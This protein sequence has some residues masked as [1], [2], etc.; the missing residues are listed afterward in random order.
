[1]VVGEAG[2]GKT[3]LAREVRR[4]LDAGGWHTELVLCSARVGFSLPALAHAA[5]TEGANEL[6]RVGRSRCL[7]D[8]SKPTVLLVDDAHLLDDESSELLWRVAGGGE[9]LV[10]ATVRSGTRVPDR[11]ARLWADGECTHLPLAPLAEGDV[12]ALLEIVLGGD[13]EDRVPRLLVRRAAGNALLLRELVRSGV[14]S[15]ALE[16]SHEV[17]RLAGELPIAAGATDLIRGNL[18]GLDSDELRALQLLAIC[19]PLRLE[20]A[21][22]IIGHGLMEA[23]E[24]Q[25]ILTMDET[26]DGPVLTFGH[27]L[28]GEVLRADIAP[29]RMRRLQNGADRGHQVHRSAQ[30]ARHLAVGY[31]AGRARRRTGPGRSAR[32]CPLGS[33][34]QPWHGRAPG[35]GCVGGDRLGRWGGVVGRNPHHARPGRRG[36]RIA[37]RDRSRCAIRGAVPIGDLRAST[38]PDPPRGSQVGHRDVHR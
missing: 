36:G 31:V 35:A 15:G 5:T 23:L 4:R 7:P 16:R 6:R 8:S 2:V 29:L 18:A 10:V 20:I 12:R 17:W 21:E 33:F 13:V 9:A 14:D 32:R 11:V 24:D 25:R 3:M 19:E 22:S 26:V 37:R 27:P 34:V 30:P 38:V 28:Y 1:V